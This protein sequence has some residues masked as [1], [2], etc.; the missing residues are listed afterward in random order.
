M[1]TQ[2]CAIARSTTSTST[3]SKARTQD[4]WDHNGKHYPVPFPYDEGIK[5][6]GGIGW[7]RDFGSEDEVDAEGVVRRSA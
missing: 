2:T 3:S 4:S 6:F 5:S 7:T 1:P